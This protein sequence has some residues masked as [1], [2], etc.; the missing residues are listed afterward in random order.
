M[1]D[2]SGRLHCRWWN[3]PFLEKQFEVGDELVVY[4][5]SGKG[6]P[7]SMDNPET[8]II[9]PGEEASIHFNRITP[10]Y[11]LT[12]GV[13]Q[14]WLR[15]LVWSA[16]EMFGPQVT[17]PWKPRS[18]TH[19][20]RQLPL[21]VVA[22]RDLHFPA[23]LE[24]VEP[25]ARRLALDEIFERQK[26]VLHRRAK[27]E[28]K[29]RALPCGGNNSLIKPFLKGLGFKLTASQEQVLREMRADLRGRH[30]MRRL[31]QGDVGSG[32]TVVSASCALMTLESG[33]DVALM[34]PTE[35]LAEQHFNLFRKWFNPLG[36]DVERRTGANKSESLVSEKESKPA[37]GLGPRMIVGTH[38]L[39]SEGFEIKNLGLVII[40]EQH[41]FGV[42]QREKLLRKGVYPHLLVMSATPIPRTLGLMLYGDLDFSIL[43]ESPK[44]RGKV[45]THLRTAKELSKVWEFVR[46]EL[47]TGR[48]AYIVFPRVE[49]SE[50][51]IQ[52]AKLQFEVLQKA[53]APHK[54]GLAYGG[55][56]NP[57]LQRV[58][59]DFRTNRVQGL[60]ATSLIEVGVDVPNA[61]IMVIQSA[62]VFGLSQ[63][64]QLRGR[65]GRG[66][67][68]AH[69]ILISNA[70]QGAGRIKLEVIQKSNDGFAIAEA[71]LKLRGPG[72]LLGQQQSGSANLRFTEF[73]NDLNLVLLGRELAMAEFQGKGNEN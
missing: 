11:P 62:E 21:R 3:Q 43:N 10:I 58:M 56:A 6:K 44:G 38:A 65:I 24:A 70:T 49:E 60:V 45:Q 47:K 34:A 54:I 42:A 46:H 69:C 25:A 2:G 22:L 4:G 12:E 51:E 8:E 31:L 53:L 64:H 27:F 13:S 41:K 61:T 14:R 68:A 48:Q 9:E 33:F 29:A 17:E 15:R 66:G 55:M 32:K 36:I 19:R 37:S 72:E 35:I 23:A 1:D 39:I 52:A 67:H 73:A 30:P 16:L 50:G 28:E 5:K 26:A 7:R 57:E 63:L 59:E 71:D 40:D 18:P 20:E